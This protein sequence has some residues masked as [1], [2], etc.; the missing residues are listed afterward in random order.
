[1][2]DYLNKGKHNLNCY[3]SQS[4]KKIN[5]RLREKRIKLYYF[6]VINDYKTIIQMKLCITTAILIIRLTISLKQRHTF[7][8]FNNSFFSDKD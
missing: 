5:I 4:C 6:S 3:C 8:G 1:M 7:K 2:V